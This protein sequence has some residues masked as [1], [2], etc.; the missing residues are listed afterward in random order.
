M[1][2]K[3]IG[4]KIASERVKLHLTQT[5]LAEKL[6]VSPK[7]VSK[8]ESG[9]G[10]PSI[11]FLPE[12]SIMFGISIDDLLCKE[13]IEKTKTL[14]EDLNTM[15][16]FRILSPNYVNYPEQVKEQLKED[17][18]KLILKDE[19]I[20]L[21]EYYTFVNNRCK[22]K[23]IEDC[24]RKLF[25]MDIVSNSGIQKRLRIGYPKAVKIRTRL[26]IENLIDEE[27]FEWLTKDSDKVANILSEEL[28][29][30]S[31]NE[32][33]DDLTNDSEYDDIDFNNVNLIN[34]SLTDE[35][36]REALEL[37]KNCSEDERHICDSALSCLQRENVACSLIMANY[38]FNLEIYTLSSLNEFKDK[39][40]EP[41]CDQA[42]VIIEA[43]A[44]TELT[45]IMT[46][47]NFKVRAEI[48]IIINNEIKNGCKVTIF[49]VKYDEL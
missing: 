29:E 20:E 11:E 36:K 33:N 4:Q 16:I 44:Q 25:T 8:W 30:F 21:S 31:I 6:C 39:V 35:Q 48:G 14:K 9:K 46:L 32:I 45:D 43:N 23:S 26:V 1:D 3:K 40:K 27:N 15:A 49:H 10:L 12:L 18:L 42:F 38:C 47:Y 22:P 28:K 17:W 19:G 2:Y 34:D 7:T 41:I 37:L 24:V 5:S 13:E